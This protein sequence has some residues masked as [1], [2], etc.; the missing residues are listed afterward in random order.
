[1]NTAIFLG[2]LFAYATSAPGLLLLGAVAIS[3]GMKWRLIVAGTG[4]AALGILM[5]L[6]E[7]ATAAELGFTP[8]P[9]LTEV[10]VCVSGYLAIALAISLVVMVA[11]SILGRSGRQNHDGQ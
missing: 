5:H 7:R 8:T 11:R 6:R 4:G 9:L 2:T 1:M 10:L 3:P